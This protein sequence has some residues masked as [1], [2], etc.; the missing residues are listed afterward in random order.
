MKCPAWPHLQQ[1]QQASWVEVAPPGSLHVRH[2]PW[3]ATWGRGPPLGLK[4]LL[5]FPALAADAC[6]DFS[7][8]YSLSVIL[9]FFSVISS[10]SFEISVT[11]AS[12]S[13]PKP[14]P[15]GFDLWLGT[16][17][18]GLLALWAPWRVIWVGWEGTFSSG[19]SS[20]SSSGAGAT[21]CTDLEG[22]WR[23]SRPEDAGL[24]ASM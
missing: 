23:R 15:F 9:W 19:P 2:L 14:R 4:G 3:G 18:V 11:Q 12:L 13:W 5:W 17:F 10:L 6:I 22:R 21:I 7:I 16:E 24:H 8:W 1:A 20:V